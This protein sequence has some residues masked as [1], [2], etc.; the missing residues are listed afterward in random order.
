MS[1][2]KVKADGNVK[3][4]ITKNQA[5]ALRAILRRRT[6]H[7][8]A[9]W[10]RWVTDTYGLYKSLNDALGQDLDPIDKAGAWLKNGDGNPI[11]G[12]HFEV[13]EK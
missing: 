10:V 12:F 7:R 8:D 4:V 6:S 3:L 5:F 11:S 2:V 13:G 9:V 1:R